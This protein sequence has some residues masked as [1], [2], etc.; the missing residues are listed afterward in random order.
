MRTPSNSIKQFKNGD[1]AYFH[2]FGEIPRRAEPYRKQERAPE[3]N[4]GAIISKW[5]SVTS[6]QQLSEYA[7]ELGVKASSL[8]ELRV[9]WS[10]EHGAWGWP[11]RDGKG[12]IVGIRLRWSDGRKRCVTGSHNALFYPFCAPQKTVWVVEGGTDAAAALSIGLFAVGR[13]SCNG[14]LSDLLE[15]VTSLG[16]DR[17]V[18]IADNDDDKERADGSKYNPGIDGGTS[19]AERIGIPCCVVA[20]PCKDLRE[21]VRLGMNAEDIENLTQGVLWHTN[22]TTN[23]TKSS[24]S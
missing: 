17:A 9:A 10:R 13:P 12:R 18:I 3:I 15:V 2:R 20:L 7:S 5:R 24:L 1:T 16:L 11:M 8:M 19:L 14:G 22:Q 6:A 4:A 21:G 23:Q